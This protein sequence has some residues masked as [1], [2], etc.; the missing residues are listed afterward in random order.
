MV[1]ATDQSIDA[2]IVKAN[3][4][5]ALNLYAATRQRRGNLFFSPYGIFSALAMVYAGARGETA[6]QMSRGL[7]LLLD[8]A[9]VH[10][11]FAALNNRL[12]SAGPADSYLLTMANAL[13]GADGVGFRAD[14]LET[15][16]AAYGA[17]VRELDFAGNPEGARQTINQWV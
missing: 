17:M 15:V 2:G 13:W 16:Q 4:E 6:L 3:N 1:K 8:Q 9:Q 11:G 14:F 10:P 12:R 7:H 5:F